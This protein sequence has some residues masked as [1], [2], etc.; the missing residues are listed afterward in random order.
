MPGAALT[1]AAS[2]L[3]PVL[4]SPALAG[5]VSRSSVSASPVSARPAFARP[6]FARPAFARPAA[7]RPAFGSSLSR[8]VTSAHALSPFPQTVGRRHISMSAVP[9]VSEGDTIKT[10][11]HVLSE[12]SAQE[13][14]HSPGSA[15]LG[16][17]GASPTVTP[18]LG[19]RE[20]TRAGKTFRV[21]PVHNTGRMD[22]ENPMLKHT[23]AE[24]VN[25]GDLT[26]A[27]ML[28]A[29]EFDK[30]FKESGVT[31]KTT[32]VAGEEGGKRTRNCVGY[33]RDLYHHLSGVML[34][35]ENNAFT[36]DAVT[37]GKEFHAQI[38]AGMKARGYI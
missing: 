21:G 13:L 31:Y 22:S 5:A 2:A 29:R 34:P 17:S 24:S 26:A 14:S 32:D 19:I 23:S 37:A 35:L 28:A 16:W 25:F 20:V 11:G 4:R 15:R 9:T 7:A 38:T 27:G 1:K 33:Q 30:S 18:K 10:P 8:S 6:A 12:F 36:Q 3:S